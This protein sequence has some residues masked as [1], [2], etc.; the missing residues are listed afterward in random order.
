[1]IATRHEKREIC[2]NRFHVNSVVS[3]YHF[4]SLSKQ[5]KEDNDCQTCVEHELDEGEK[6]EREKRVLLK[7][8]T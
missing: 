4:Y 3:I 6:G 7:D 1:M 2:V 5:R 8:E